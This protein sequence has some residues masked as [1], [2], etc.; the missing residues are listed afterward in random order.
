MCNFFSFLVT[1]KKLITFYGVNAHEDILEIAGIKDDRLS[2][3]FVR[4]ELIPN[5][6]MTLEFEKWDFNVSQDYRP[7]WFIEEEWRQKAIEYL[8]SVPTVHRGEK[9]NILWDKYWF[10]EGEIDNMI[11]QSGLLHLIGGRVDLITGGRVNRITGGRVDRITGGQVDRI[12][13]DAKI[14]VDERAKKGDK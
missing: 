13:G 8:K 9:I 4:C 2:P 11:A 6:P 3:K 12:D 1:R 7:D 14:G 10:S 5:N